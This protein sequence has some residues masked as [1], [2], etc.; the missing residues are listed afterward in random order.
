MT[1]EEKIM[2]MLKQIHH[3]NSFIM[4]SLTALTSDHSLIKITEGIVEE[5]DKKFKAIMEGEENGIHE[6]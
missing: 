6:N 3:E 2:E 4:S 1:N 5:W